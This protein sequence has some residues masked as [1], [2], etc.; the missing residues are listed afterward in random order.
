M[1]RTYLYERQ[2]TYQAKDWYISFDLTSSGEFYDIGKAIERPLMRVNPE[3]KNMLAETKVFLMSELVEH[4]REIYSLLDL[5]G[6]LGGVTE[7]IMIIFGCILFPIS[8]HEFNLQSA[9]RLFLAHTQDEE[10][11]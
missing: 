5:L 7:V 9:K 4:E 10:I 11:F 2:Q 6:D 8:E 1:D 3:H